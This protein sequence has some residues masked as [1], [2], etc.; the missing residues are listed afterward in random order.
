MQRG[1]DRMPALHLAAQSLERLQLLCAY[2][3]S[4][5]AVD[6]LH[7]IET[8]SREC[9]RWLA[10]TRRWSSRLHHIEFRSLERVRALLVGGADVR[11]GDDEADAPTPLSLATERLLRSGGSDDGRAALIVRATAPSAAAKA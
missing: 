10:A 4:R 2:A 5:E 7:L 6:A 1:H 8:A 3:P 9:A 11:A